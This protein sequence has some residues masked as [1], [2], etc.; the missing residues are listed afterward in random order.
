KPFEN[1]PI[2]NTSV[3]NIIV[4]ILLGHRFDHGDPT[5]L[6][7]ISLVNENFKLLGSPMVALY[8]MYPN[9]IRWLPGGHRTVF[10]NNSQF[11]NFI[12]KTFTKQKSQLD[13]NHQGNL[14]DAFLIKQLE[15]TFNSHLRCY[16]KAL[17]DTV[18]CLYK[19]INLFITRGYFGPLCPE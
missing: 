13:V 10:K 16:K 12:T 15:V 1:T 19:H 2:I 4:S 11:K 9:I 7:L 6:T 17:L 3:V 18:Q 14:I 8:N 5:I